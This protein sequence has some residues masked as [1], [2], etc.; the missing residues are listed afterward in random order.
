MNI[1]LCLTC[2]VYSDEG[3]T[4]HTNSGAYKEMGFKNIYV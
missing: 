4:K 1:D 2:K 3:A